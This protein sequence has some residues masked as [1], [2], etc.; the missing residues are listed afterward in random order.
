M[1]VKKLIRNLMG[2]K[3]F[4]D[5]FFDLD[6]VICG[7][8]RKSIAPSG[9]PPLEF[10]PCPACGKSLFVPLLVSDFMLF[11]PAGAGGMASVYKAYHRE[12]GNECCAVK[13]L[14]NE[15]RDDEKVV[16]DFLN[17]A[18]IHSQVP[19]HPHLVHFIESGYDNDLYFYAMNFVTGEKL[20]RLVEQ[21]GRL[22]ENHALLILDQVLSAVEH[23]AANGYLYR[24]VNA[25]NIILPSDKNAI[26]LDFGLAMPS[27]EADAPVVDMK[28][29][30]GTP[31]YL[32]P[33]RL[34]GCGEDERSTTY[35]LGHLATFMMTGAAIMKGGSITKMANKHVS[36]LRLGRRS[37]V[38]Q[39]I[40]ER[41]LEFID[42]MTAQQP[43]DRFESFAATREAIA[44]LG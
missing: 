16:R 36:S 28:E 29:V 25:A 38:P 30:F 35:S 32:P 11:E 10:V 44:A 41:T 43:A 13:I 39:D 18:E 40:S 7:E 37:Y 20:L 1:P 26:L 2:A 4:R 23:I 17:E 21:R 5:T 3:S 33:E 27:D 42:R 34:V 24:D 19:D 15:F 31:E 6:A 14:K 22:Q 9:L 8:C 12:R